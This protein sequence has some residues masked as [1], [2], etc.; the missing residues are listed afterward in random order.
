MDKRLEYVDV[1]KGIGMICVIAI[2]VSNTTIFSSPYIKGYYMPIFFFLSGLFIKELPF[3]TI[4]IKKIIPYIFFS[5]LAIAVKLASDYKS[6]NE[7]IKTIINPYDCINGPLW[8]LLSLFWGNLIFC[9]V[10]Q[11]TKRT[12]FRLFCFISISMVGFY[13]TKMTIYNHHI[14]FPLFLSTSM[15]SIIFIYIGFVYKKHINL[16]RNKFDVI[17][18]VISISI[19]L[20]ILLY[21][22]NNNIEMIWNKYSLPYFPTVLGGISISLSLLYICKFLK[23]VPIISH[24]GKY[25]LIVLST[26]T[27][28]I[29]FINKISVYPYLNILIIILISYPIIYILK[30][31]FPKFCAHPPLIKK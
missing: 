27:I 2:H 4:L 14:I 9:Y 30:T 18:L 28:L 29:P 7:I 10:L 26:H 5:I 1:A 12:L 16:E 17:Y 6:Y 25:S 3:K 23:R 22:G 11:K 21:W 13:L 31:Y 20:F 15:T 8:F 19:Y 24:I